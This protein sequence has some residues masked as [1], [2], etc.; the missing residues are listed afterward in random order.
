VL[1]PGDAADLDTA[2][3]VEA[4]AEPI[5]DVSKSQGLRN[6][7]Y[8]QTLENFIRPTSGSR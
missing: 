5:R 6:L 1:N 4:A 2:V 7:G 8:P 3:S